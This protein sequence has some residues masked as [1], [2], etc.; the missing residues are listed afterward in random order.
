M[1]SIESAWEATQVM[2]LV[3]TIQRWLTLTMSTRVYKATKES[4]VSVR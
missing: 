4:T 3:I 1:T 2:V